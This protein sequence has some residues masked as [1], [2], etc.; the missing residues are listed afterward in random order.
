MSTS[1]SRFL[2]LR[3]ECS[4]FYE[5]VFILGVNLPDRKLTR[6]CHTTSVCKF[7]VNCPYNY[8]DSPNSLLRHWA[9]FSTTHMCSSPHSR[10]SAGGRTLIP[11]NY[12]PRVLPFFALNCTSTSPPPPRTSIE[13][14]FLLV[15]ST[16]S[17]QC[18]NV[19]RNQTAKSEHER[20][21]PQA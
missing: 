17:A 7:V 2:V 10:C 4:I 15:I 16:N 9:Q 3:L 19:S 13:F 5:M 14:C 20:S 6:V 18:S 12:R 1:H 21:S 11:A 8:L